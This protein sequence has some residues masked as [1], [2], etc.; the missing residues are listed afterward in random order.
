MTKSLWTSSWPY[1]GW[2]CSF[3]PRRG[4]E[5]KQM[6]S[7]WR[8]RR[9]IAGFRGVRRAHFRDLLL[10]C[11]NCEKWSQLVQRFPDAK[12]YS[13]VFGTMTPKYLY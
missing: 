6:I 8:H 7:S 3:C 9:S 10:F 1:S 12:S 11:V 13:V 4:L 5:T 2:G